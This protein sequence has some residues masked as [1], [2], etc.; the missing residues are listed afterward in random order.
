[1]KSAV[2]MQGMMAKTPEAR[3]VVDLKFHF[4]PSTLD[5]RVSFDS[6]GWDTAASASRGHSYCWS[7]WKCAEDLA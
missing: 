7:L 3:A 4:M 6:R 5:E 1:M 2:C